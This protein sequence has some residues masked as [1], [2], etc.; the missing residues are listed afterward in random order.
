MVIESIASKIIGTL[1][2]STDASK[3]RLF[4]FLLWKELSCKVEGEMLQK[5]AY[6]RKMVHKMPNIKNSGT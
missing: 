5:F 6:S 3:S 1:R 2:H 4:Q